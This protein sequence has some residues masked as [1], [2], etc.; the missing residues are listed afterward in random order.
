MSGNVSQKRLLVQVI[1]LFGIGL[2]WA[3]AT[4]LASQNPA[5]SP[6]HRSQ[7]SCYNGQRDGEETGIDCRLRGDLGTIVQKG[8]KVVRAFLADAAGGRVL[9]DGSC[10]DHDWEVDEARFLDPAEAL[11]RVRDTQRP[12]LERALAMAAGR[13]AEGGG[14]CAT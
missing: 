5:P 2:L 11:R 6:D 1:L 9:P 4:A 12:L 13:A 3:V 10:P 7:A 14:R 8:G